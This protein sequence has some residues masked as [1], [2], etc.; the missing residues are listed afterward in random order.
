MLRLNGETP[1]SLL[2]E[3]GLEPMGVAGV[4]PQGDTLTRSCQG[5]ARWDS[6]RP[7][8]TAWASQGSASP[9]GLP[10]DP[11]PQVLHLTNEGTYICLPESM[12]GCSQR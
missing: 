5:L 10:N 12:W 8:G 4:A 6:E 3:L 11:E 1:Q 2:G 9:C 7:C